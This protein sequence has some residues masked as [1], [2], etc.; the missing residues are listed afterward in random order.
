MKGKGK[1]NL[2][3]EKLLEVCSTVLIDFNFRLFNNEYIV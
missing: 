3:V 2:F 1:F